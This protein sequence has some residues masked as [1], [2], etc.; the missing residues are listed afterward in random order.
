MFLPANPL[1]EGWFRGI[2]GI[3]LNQPLC[4]GGWHLVGYVSIPPMINGSNLRAVLLI[5][6]F[7]CQPSLHEK[8]VGLGV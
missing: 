7:G 2:H 6:Y 1:N 3:L 4:C 5:F 8:R